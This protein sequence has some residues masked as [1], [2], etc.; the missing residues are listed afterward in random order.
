MPVS[1]VYMKKDAW[2]AVAVVL[3]IVG[4][5]YFYRAPLQQMFMGSSQNAMPAESMEGENMMSPEP[6][7]MESSE[8]M[9]SPAPTGM[10]NESMSD[11]TMTKNDPTKGNYLVGSNGMTLYSYDK[12]TAGVSN[13]YDTCAEKWPPYA[14]TNTSSTLPTNVSVVKRTDGSMMYAYK[15]MPLYF[16]VGDAKPGDT[17]GDGVGGVWHLVKP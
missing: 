9:M 16:W 4:I 6:T 13:C 1:L 2:V 5:A 14:A 3:V 7:A 15:G 12:D 17:T 10:E 11:I 8:A